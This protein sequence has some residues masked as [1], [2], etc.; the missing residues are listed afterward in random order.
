MRFRF[1]LL[2]TEE[3]TPWGKPPEQ[4]LS[5]FALT[6]GYFYIDTDAGPL[7][8]YSP[9]V[10]KRFD[11][12]QPGLQYQV[13]GMARCVL[14]VLSAAIAPVPQALQDLMA[15]W[16]RFSSQLRAE[17]D[18]EEGYT[19]SR[20]L[21]ERSGGPDFFL[22]SPRIY[23]VRIGD[24]IQV[25]W[26]HRAALTD[27]EP[28]FSGPQVGSVLVPLADF[29][30]EA[31]RFADGLLGAME[32]RFDNLESG[33]C[34]TQIEV[35]VETLRLHHKEWV[36]EFSAYFVETYEPDIEWDEALAAIRRVIARY[37][38]GANPANPR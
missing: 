10:Y 31:R 8:C 2:P 14:D 22:S 21:G 6:D 1:Q 25:C 38:S 29:L 37:G 7:C 3:I 18:S 5:W 9:A 11:S 27:G 34:S 30:A 19:A 32:T 36:D 15:D 4:A 23:F 28:T 20:W 35:S 26:D 13:A 17:E 16:P 24:D 12:Q 33:A